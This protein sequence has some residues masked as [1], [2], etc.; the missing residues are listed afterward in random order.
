MRKQPTLE[1]SRW[2]TIRGIHDDGRADVQTDA[3]NILRRVEVARELVLVQGQRVD[4]EW[5]QDKY[6]VVQNYGTGNPAS[7]LVVPVAGVSASVARSGRGGKLAAAWDAGPPGCTYDVTVT[8]LGTGVQRK[9]TTTDPH[10]DLNID[11]FN[12]QKVEVVTVTHF[13]HSLPVEAGT[14]LGLPSSPIGV[15]A[16]PGVKK[17]TVYW[18]WAWSDWDH[19][20]IYRSTTATYDA[21]ALYLGVS[22]IHSFVD[23][24]PDIIDPLTG[25]PGLIAGTTYYYWVLS[26]DILGQKDHVLLP[27]EAAMAF[28]TPTSVTAYDLEWWIGTLYNERIILSPSNGG[29]TAFD[30]QGAPFF[31]VNCTTPGFRLGFPDGPAFNF[32]PN[33]TENEPLI[34]IDGD[35][36]IDAS[37]SVNK[38]NIG[39]WQRTILEAGMYCGTGDPELTPG[40][41]G[42][43]TGFIGTEDDMGWYY[44]MNPVLTM[45]WNSGHLNTRV[46]EQDFDYLDLGDDILT[47]YSTGTH[48]SI[49]L[50][51]FR[52]DLGS[53]VYALRE[54]VGLRATEN[55]LALGHPVAIGKGPHLELLDGE[56]SKGWFGNGGFFSIS[57]EGRFGIK[58][59]TQGEL[60]FYSWGEIVNGDLDWETGLAFGY[61]RVSINGAV[62][63]VG[64]PEYGSGLGYRPEGRNGDLWYNPETDKFEG[65]LSTGW[66]TFNTTAIEA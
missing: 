55:G 3:G 40:T 18:N 61:E 64:D 46:D 9:I 63:N 33:A 36:V 1:R 14:E 24:G 54:Q 12:N 53:G 35:V 43:F 25:A 22:T 56:S 60:G 21:T 58:T 29:I 50:K 37:L 48:A 27:G 2:G 65:K 20:E 41:E 6:R 7:N 44:R 57:D 8:D 10:L 62:L 13:G 34:A 30:K 59:G 47:G 32:D 11:A 16:E 31:F 38:L 42:A 45:D 26:V 19:V 15:T 51:A 39:E 4:L 66:V 28:A 52:M 23:N 17:I 49:L 5:I